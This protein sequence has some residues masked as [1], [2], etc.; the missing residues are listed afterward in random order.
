MRLTKERLEEIK[1]TIFVDGSDMLDF[2]SEEYKD[3]KPFKDEHKQ[4]LISEIDALVRERDQYKEEYDELC[5]FANIFE[6]Q[7]DKFKKALKQIELNTRNNSVIGYHNILCV[8][9][10]YTNNTAFKALNST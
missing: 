9:C 7:K 1:K 4:E 6:E 10:E 3:D 2:D 8:E 5:M